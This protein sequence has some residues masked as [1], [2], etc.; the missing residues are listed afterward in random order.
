MRFV[1][2][3]CRSLRGEVHAAR[4]RPA[5]RARQTERRS[6]AR[7]SVRGPR[8]DADASLVRAYG[9]GLHK[10]FIGTYS[11]TTTLRQLSLASLHGR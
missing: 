1:M 10:G 11:P 4:E 2:T 6:R 8:L 9:D 5:L 7:K 3:G